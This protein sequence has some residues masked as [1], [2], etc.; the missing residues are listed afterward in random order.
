VDT[1]GRIER[2]RRKYGIKTETET[3]TAGTAGAAS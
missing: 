2:F 1:A 3:D